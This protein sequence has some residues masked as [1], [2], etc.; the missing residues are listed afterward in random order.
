MNVEIW[1]EGGREIPFLRI[2]KWDFR[3]GAQL[4]MKSYISQCVIQ[5]VGGGGRA[6]AGFNARLFMIVKS[7]KVPHLACN[8]CL[9]YMYNNK[10][11]SYDQPNV[12]DHPP[13][14]LIHC[15]IISIETLCHRE[16]THSASPC[17]HC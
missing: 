5:R 4:A 1:T 6:A 17:L 10:Q 13:L 9:R 16:L 2:H 7:F 14:P 11:D 8:Q 15:I 12:T 3:S